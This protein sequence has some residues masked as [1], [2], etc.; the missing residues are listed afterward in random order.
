MQCDLAHS[1]CS[2]TP[3]LDAAA[4]AAADGH[5]VVVAATRRGQRDVA[6]STL[7]GSFVLRFF[8]SPRCIACFFYHALKSVTSRAGFAIAI[9]ELAERAR[10]IVFATIRG[11]FSM[12]KKRLRWR[13]L[14]S[15]CILRFHFLRLGM[16]TFPINVFAS[17]NR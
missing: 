4:A 14:I 6:W 12:P 13:F 7:T 5:P 15:G 9:I 10:V 16:D 8:S 2:V 1:S 3:W 11:S 17:E